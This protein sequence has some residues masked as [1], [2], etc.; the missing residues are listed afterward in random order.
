MNNYVTIMQTMFLL[1][2]SSEHG[3][4]I[5]QYLWEIL[6]TSLSVLNCVHDGS[7]G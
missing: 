2:C 4:S 5:S 7:V 1:C 6:C 3:E